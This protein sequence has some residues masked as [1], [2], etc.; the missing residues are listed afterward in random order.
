MNT[1]KLAMLSSYVKTI[2]DAIESCKEH[3]EGVKGFGLTVH[4][5]AVIDALN[6]IHNAE[7]NDIIFS[8]DEMP[9]QKDLL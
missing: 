4:T 2:E 9:E 3:A 7:E 1:E 6:E 8:D 5:D